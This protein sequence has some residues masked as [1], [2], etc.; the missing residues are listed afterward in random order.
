MAKTKPTAKQLAARKKFAAAV[1][2]GKFRKG[3]KSKS[4]PRTKTV[5]K[6]IT[7]VRRV[8]NMAKRKSSSSTRGSRK[9]KIPVLSS[10]MFKKA[11][12]GAGV[13]TLLTFGLGL[14]GQQQLAANPAVKAL[15][16]FAVGDVTGAAAAFLTGGGM[17]G[18]GTSNQQNTGGFA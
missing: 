8:K 15:A 9:M 2:A 14:I 7:K 1:K 16:G 18:L 5:T 4:K 11:A 13:G 17:Q 10:P 3:K 12:A 6:V